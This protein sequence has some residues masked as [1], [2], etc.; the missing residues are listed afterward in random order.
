MAR[1]IPS[2]AEQNTDRQKMVVHG[3]VPTR[4]VMSPPVLQ[5][6][7]ADATSH[8]PRRWLRAAVPAI[9]E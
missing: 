6:T 4:R 9:R 2:T 5:H 7:A 3:S 1:A 8:N